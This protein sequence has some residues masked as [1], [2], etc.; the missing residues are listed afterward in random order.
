MG[1]VQVDDGA[2]SRWQT[3]I[4]ST[5]SK[6]STAA[7][8][9]NLTLDELIRGS[10]WPGTVNSGPP[11]AKQTTSEE[12]WVKTAADGQPRVSCHR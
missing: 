4:H 7:K 10:V 5:E 1:G 9:E 6:G 11:G 2:I 3:T 8:K 12:R